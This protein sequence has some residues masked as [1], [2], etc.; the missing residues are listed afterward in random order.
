MMTEESISKRNLRRYIPLR[1]VAVRWFLLSF[2]G[3]VVAS[4]YYSASDWKPSTSTMCCFTVPR[5]VISIHE[6]TGAYHT[7][8][9]Y[10][11]WVFLYVFAVA[12]RHDLLS[13]QGSTC[14]RMPSLTMKHCGCSLMGEAKL[15]RTFSSRRAA[16]TLNTSSCSA[17]NSMPKPKT[18][19]SPVHSP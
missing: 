7:S 13:S 3:G 6:R 14:L 12:I 10:I 8:H 15:F 19:P 11:R 18:G 4:A 5:S 17:P 16:S 2:I 9:R 1:T